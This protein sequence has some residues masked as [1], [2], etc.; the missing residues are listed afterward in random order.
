M[1][2]QFEQLPEGLLDLEARQLE[3]LLG[4]PSL[5][6]LDGRQGDS[7][8]VSVLMHGNETTGWEAVRRSGRRFA[9]WPIL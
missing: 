5:F 7:L 1:L 6:R 8:F 4:G 2:Q 9:P 3:G